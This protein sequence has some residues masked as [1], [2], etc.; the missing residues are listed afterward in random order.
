MNCPYFECYPPY[1]KKYDKGYT[2]NQCNFCGYYIKVGNKN[3]VI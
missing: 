3:I 2:I 1:E